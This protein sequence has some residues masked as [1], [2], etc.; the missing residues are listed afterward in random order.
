MKKRI[1]VPMIVIPSIVISAAV[2]IASAGIT[3]TEVP[4]ANLMEGQNIDPAQDAMMQND[5][6]TGQVT[7]AQGGNT[8]QPSLN[9]VAPN[10]WSS[11]YPFTFEISVRVSS[12]HFQITG[13][14]VEIQ[15]RAAL[16]P[17]Y[18]YNGYG[19]FTYYMDLFRDHWYGF[20]DLGTKTL[21]YDYTGSGT[22]QTPTWSG[23]GPG[24]YNFEV[25]KRDDGVW[26][27]GDGT[28]YQQ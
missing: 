16:D 7:P 28:V 9:T 20:D 23:V 19:D 14:S 8:L 4:V 11:V 3:S 27:K 21:S 10:S 2:P 22:Y 12:N 17:N 13:N 15:T 26:I 25:S 5:I 6:Q 1:V 18:P 24:E